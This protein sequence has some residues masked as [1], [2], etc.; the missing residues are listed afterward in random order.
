MTT[1]NIFLDLLNNRLESLVAKVCENMTDPAQSTI[2]INQKQRSCKGR[3]RRIHIAYLKVWPLPCEPT[4]CLF[5][6]HHF[7]FSS[8]L[9]N[10]GWIKHEYIVELLK[11]DSLDWTKTTVE[12]TTNACQRKI[13]LLPI[14]SINFKTNFLWSLSTQDWEVSLCF[15]VLKLVNYPFMG[16]PDAQ[17]SSLR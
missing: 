14:N 2:N 9:S 1:N 8:Y 7:I 6:I 4:R 16:F 10:R 5:R 12:Q 11:Y 17:K 13:L 3:Q 15:K